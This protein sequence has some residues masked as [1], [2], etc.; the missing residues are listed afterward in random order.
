MALTTSPA[1]PGASRRGFS[2]SS[3]S[4]SSSFTSRIAAAAVQQI[5][6]S[7][8]SLARNVISAVAARTP[9]LGAPTRTEQ[10]IE[11]D[12]DYFTGPQ[13]CSNL[14]ADPPP[15]KYT[16]APTT[17]GFSMSDSTVSLPLTEPMPVS[18]RSV[19][20]GAVM[21][22]ASTPT[23]SNAGAC[24]SCSHLKLQLHLLTLQNEAYMAQRD[25][26]LQHESLP[27]QAPGSSGLLS[28]LIA[29][30]IRAMFLLAFLVWPYI[31]G[32]LGRAREWEQEWEVGGRVRSWG[33]RCVGLAW[34][35]VLGA[36]R[37]PHVGNV[38]IHPEWEMW[39]TKLLEEVLSGVGQGV[40]EGLGV[41]GVR[42]ESVM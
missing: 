34:N 6:G 1:A 15:P 28:F 38:R 8:V 33:W 9:L 31:R 17:P 4:S 27:S 35:V 12:A 19:S 37:E 24:T 39:A 41:W 5:P 29:S 2:S 13:D 16:S 22:Q 14:P 21:S 40:R 30:V 42:M 36:S 20:L 25:Y 3:S 26:L 18:S 11:I 32:V 10:A 23:T 7:Y